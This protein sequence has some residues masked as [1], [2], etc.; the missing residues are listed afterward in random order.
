MDEQKSFCVLQNFVPFGAAAQEVDFRP[1]RTDFRLMRA[2]RV[3]DESPNVFYRTVPFQA[4]A[5]L[6]LTSMHNHAQQG[7]GYR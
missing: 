1:E 7:N 3:A 5:L 6:P 4:T 2:G